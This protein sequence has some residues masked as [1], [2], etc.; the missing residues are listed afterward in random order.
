MKLV[1]CVFLVTLVTGCATPFGTRMQEDKGG[2]WIVE[3]NF[4]I[5]SWWNEVI[6][7]EN[8]PRGSLEIPRPRCERVPLGEKMGPAGA[9]R[10]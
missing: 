7:C 10:P 9:F 1:I 2:V 6:Y 5:I 4:A 3:H 8:A